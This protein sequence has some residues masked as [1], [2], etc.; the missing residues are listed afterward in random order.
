MNLS[1]LNTTE[2]DLIIEALD[3]LPNKNQAGNMMVDLLGMMLAGKDEES[4]S[5]V[6]KEREDRRI[7]EEEEKAELKEAVKILQ[8][9]I[10][11]IKQN[12]K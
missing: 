5:F 10:L 3:Y 1:E 11:I 7:K 9:K 12:Q 6:E 8:A 2:L 4:K